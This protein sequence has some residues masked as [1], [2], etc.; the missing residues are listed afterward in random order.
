[1]VDIQPWRNKALEGRYRVGLRRIDGSCPTVVGIDIWL[2]A[3]L[4]MKAQLSP[5]LLQSSVYSCVR[6]VFSYVAPYL[7]WL[8]AFHALDRRLG[9][10]QVLYHKPGRQACFAVCSI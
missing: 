6:F 3:A 1:M 8:A 10:S 7:L 4:K 2:V 5:T 9:C